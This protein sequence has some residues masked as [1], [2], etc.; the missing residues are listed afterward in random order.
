MKW[1]RPSGNPIETNDRK[2]TIEHCEKLGWEMMGE[3]E[4]IAPDPMTD[5]EMEPMTAEERAEIIKM[6]VIE[7]IN[8]DDPE[9]LIASGAPEVKEVEKLTEF[10]I[11]AEERDIAFADAMHEES[12]S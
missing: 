10:P 7:I 12:E 5:S 4:V 2:E 3:K 9:K 6:A 11:S 8:Q 1:M